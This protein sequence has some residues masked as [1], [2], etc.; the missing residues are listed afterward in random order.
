MRQDWTIDWL[1]DRIQLF[2]DFCY[3]SLNA[4]INQNFKWLVFFDADT[5]NNIKNE[6]NQLRKWKNFI[7]IYI[8]DNN[9]NTIL[10]NIKEHINPKAKYLITS[11]VDADDGY[12]VDYVQRVQDLF[13]KYKDGNK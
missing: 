8:H 1:I 7:P 6:I 9:K 10:A 5:P 3:P 2:E 11:R 13:L 12:A 4:Q